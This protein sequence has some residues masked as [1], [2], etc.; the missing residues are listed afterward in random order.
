MSQSTGVG[1]GGHCVARYGD[2]SLVESMLEVAAGFCIFCL[3]LGPRA[4]GL[5]AFR[6]VRKAHLPSWYG[7]C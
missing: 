5:P 3:Y 4:A 1:F 2:D 6:P 7:M